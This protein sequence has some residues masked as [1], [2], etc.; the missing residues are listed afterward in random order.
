MKILNASHGARLKSEGQQLALEFSG[1]WKDTV[2]IE[3]RGWLAAQRAMGFTTCT[4]EQFRAQAKAQPK[5]PQAWGSVPR[6]AC[7]AGLIEPMKTADGHKVYRN[8]AAPRTRSHPVQVYV[9]RAAA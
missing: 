9:V 4:V 7:K 5:T 8:A 1:D 6:L 3:L 2:L